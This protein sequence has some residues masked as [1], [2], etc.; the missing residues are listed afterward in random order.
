[1]GCNVAQHCSKPLCS[2]IRLWSGVSTQDRRR[3]TLISALV[4]PA[5]RHRN[6][7]CAAVIATA[8]IKPDNIS[9]SREDGFSGQMDLDV[10]QGSPG[11]TGAATASLSMQNSPAKTPA[12]KPKHLLISRVQHHLDAH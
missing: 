6:A 4:F 3:C 9:L 5:A 12:S 1:L 2:Y 10:A 8:A 7:L 11:A